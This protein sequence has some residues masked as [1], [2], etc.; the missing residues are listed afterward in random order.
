MGMARDGEILGDRY[1]NAALFGRLA[2]DPIAMQK[3]L[4]TGR[5]L[6]EASGIP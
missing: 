6:Y 1:A 4:M 3:R 5:S 2:L